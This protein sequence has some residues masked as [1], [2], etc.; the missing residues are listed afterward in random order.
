M[1][2]ASSKHGSHGRASM[3]ALIDWHLT[4]FVPAQRLTVPQ[5]SLEERFYAKTCAFDVLSASITAAVSLAALSAEPEASGNALTL[6][7]TLQPGALAPETYR[8]G[9]R[10]QSIQGY[11]VIRQ[12]KDIEL[13]RGRNSVRFSDVAAYIDPTTVMFESLTDPAGTSVAEQNF[14]FDLVNQEK[15]LQRYIDQTIKVDQVRGNAVESFSGT[16]LSTAGGMV[17]KREDGALQTAAS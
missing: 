11:A 4:P 5:P 8:N 6:Y 15:L 2:C 3:R 14:Q 7:S 12:H 9:G 10:G 17:L 1:R 13:A 16:L